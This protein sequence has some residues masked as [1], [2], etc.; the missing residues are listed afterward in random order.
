M[1]IKNFKQFL[2]EDFADIHPKNKWE[3]IENNKYLKSI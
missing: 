3:D 2:L 1:V